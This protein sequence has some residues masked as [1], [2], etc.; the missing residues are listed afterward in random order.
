MHQA[1]MAGTD[2][3]GNVIRIPA[4]AT[5]TA[6]KVNIST[7]YAA[8]DSTGVL[9]VDTDA[10]GINLT[11][12]RSVNLSAAGSSFASVMITSQ[13]SNLHPH[14]I[15]FSSDS[16]NHVYIS[17]S[18]SGKT[19]TPILEIDASTLNLQLT[20]GLQVGGA[21]PLGHTLVGNGTYYKDGLIAAGI[22]GTGAAQYV[23]VFTDT[24]TI[25]ASGMQVYNSGPATILE[26]LAKGIDIKATSA[27]STIAL[28]VLDHVSGVHG[29]ELTAGSEPTLSTLSND[30]LT[31]QATVA[32][33]NTMDSNDDFHSLEITS[34]SN[35]IVH[36]ATSSADTM[37]LEGSFINIATTN[38]LKIN[39]AAPAGHAL[40]GNGTA[41][42]DTVLSTGTL[43]GS[44]AGGYLP[45]M[46][47]STTIT[48]SGLTQYASAGKAYLNS[49][50]AALVVN[51]AAVSHGVFPYSGQTSTV[52]ATDTTTDTL[53]LDS[54]NPN[55]GIFLIN[56]YQYQGLGQVSSIDFEGTSLNVTGRAINVNAGA[57]NINMGVVDTDNS[58]QMRFLYMDATSANNG[59]VRVRGDSIAPLTSTIQLL[60]FKLQLG[61]MDPYTTVQHVAS[62]DASSTSGLTYSGA[63]GPGMTIMAPPEDSLTIATTSVNTELPIM[64][65]PCDSNGANHHIMFVADSGATV[66]ISPKANNLNLDPIGTSLGVTISPTDSND[67]YHYVNFTSDS[68]GNLYIQGSGS[69]KIWL[70]SNSSGDAMSI[71]NTL[72]G[73]GCAINFNGAYVDMTCTRLRIGTLPASSSGLPSGTLYLD[74]SVVKVV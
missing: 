53:T 52:I 59:T 62:I 7:P 17:S 67:A 51:T 56:Q 43:K 19:Q 16:N 55:S 37:N 58:S 65:S 41:Y 64:I 72:S 63:V 61:A 22:Q 69:D 10:D 57:G 49:S 20:G 2:G 14:P 3:N 9:A 32:T 44:A 73:G 15:E 42:V 24:T 1:V 34:D 45:V 40:V 6:G 71:N 46:S 70:Q 18:P 4:V 28:K 8:A 27:D 23:P 50:A 30:N 12:N 54:N 47:D 66:H 5:D 36:I 74:S 25:A 39:G 38:G 68:N 11:G 13:D 48:T 31:I 33:I 26:A 21:A 60:G 35:N 29:I